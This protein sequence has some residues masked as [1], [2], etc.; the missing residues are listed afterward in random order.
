[1]KILVYGTDTFS[2]YSTFMRGL[3][4]ALKTVYMQMIAR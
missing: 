2:D 1:M 4:V 3:I